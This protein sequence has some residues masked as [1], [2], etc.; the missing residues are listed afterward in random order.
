MPRIYIFRCER[1]EYSA[2]IAG[3]EAEGYH[4]TTQTIHC[5]NCR[6]LRDVIVRER[7]PEPPLPPLKKLLPEPA[8]PSNTL[9]FGQPPRTRWT[10]RP[11]ACPVAATHEVTPWNKPGRCPHCGSF[12]EP[13]GL[14]FRI[15]E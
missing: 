10:T 8:T 6:E 9:K 11:P 4:A 12:M 7:V 13:D 5:K 15:W 2:R 3:G 1:C 14:P